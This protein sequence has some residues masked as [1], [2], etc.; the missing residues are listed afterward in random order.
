MLKDVKPK[1][2]NLPKGVINNYNVII[3]RKN[4]YD[5]QIDSDIKRYV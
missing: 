3:N 5:L 4:F 1:H 2:I